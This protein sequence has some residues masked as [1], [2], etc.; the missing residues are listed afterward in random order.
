ME[1]EKKKLKEE[2]TKLM[3]NWEKREK[4]RQIDERKHE[5]IKKKIN[6]KDRHKNEIIMISLKLNKEYRNK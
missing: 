2:K 1:G 3:R 4:K 6:M 5:G